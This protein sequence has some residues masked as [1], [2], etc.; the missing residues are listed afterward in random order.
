MTEPPANQPSPSADEHAGG[1]GSETFVQW[2]L[3]SLSEEAVIRDLAAFV[4]VAESA[5]R[6]GSPSD[7]RD[8]IK[9]HGNPVRLDQVEEAGRIWALR[10]RA[11]A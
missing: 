9:Q 6:R 8:W 1:T 4:R 2:L 3:A 11:G 7:L 10:R 5:P